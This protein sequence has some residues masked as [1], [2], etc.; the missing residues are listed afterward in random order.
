MFT[1][2]IIIT[3]A[4]PGGLALARLL[5]LRNIPTTLLDLRSRPTISELERPSGMLDLHEDTGLATIQACG[6]ERGFKEALGDCSEA[7]R[8]RTP[9]GKLLFSDEGEGANRPEIPR[10]SLVDLLVRSIPD[11]AVRWGTKVSGLRTE[12]TGPDGTEAVVSLADGGEMRADLVIGAD[13]AW[14][15]T[16]RLL[17]SSTPIYTGIQYITATARH[18]TRSHPHL[19]EIIGSGSSF[20]LGSGHGIMT[21]RGPQDSMRVYIAIKTPEEHWAEK[22]GLRGASARTAGEAVL[23]DPDLFRDWAPELREV[24]QVACEADTK[25]GY[26]SALDIKPIY[27]LPHK[28]LWPAQAGVTVLGDAAHLMAPNGEGV[29]TALAD[30]LDLSRLLGDPF[31]AETAAEWQAAVAPKLREYEKLMHERAAR[32]FADTEELLGIMH[33]EN[34]AEAMT[35]MFEGFGMGSGEAQ[36]AV[37]MSK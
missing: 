11:R 30:A 25:D 28:E 3:G 18:I 24:I 27:T 22:V 26:N 34:G 31:E 2:R 13:G 37:E 36:A 12:Q 35:A 33:G 7:V 10:A 16:R 5:H 19:L 1:P 20:A 6:L 15:K 9:S 32:S 8:I 21:H 17:T 23:S 4:G 14:S 29:N